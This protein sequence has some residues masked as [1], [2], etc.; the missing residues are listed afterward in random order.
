MAQDIVIGSESFTTSNMKPHRDEEI[1]EDYLQ[2]L[3]ANMGVMMFS[4]RNI[5]IN[6]DAL[7]PG[8]S[9]FFDPH[10]DWDGRTILAFCKSNNE[11]DL[12]GQPVGPKL[13][14]DDSLYNRIIYRLDGDD[15]GVN[16][17]TLDTTTFKLLGPYNDQF[18]DA[19]YIVAAGNGGIEV[20]NLDTNTQ[21]IHYILIVM[22]IA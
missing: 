16:I 3:A 6:N 15:V 17:H 2:K 11:T 14:E 21:V 9:H 12:G 5:L 10:Y 22:C 4:M 13:S 18:H 19:I 20:H 1:N 8:E 7:S